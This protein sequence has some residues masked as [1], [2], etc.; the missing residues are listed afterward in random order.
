MAHAIIV[1]EIGGKQRT[2]CFNNH[3]VMFIGKAC[4]CDPIDIEA[5]IMKIATE[6]GLRAL[7]IVIYGGLCGWYE[8]EAIFDHDGVTLKDVTGWIGDANVDEFASVWNVFA[9]A[10]A[11][12]RATEKQIK[13]Y[14]NKLASGEIKKKTKKPKTSVH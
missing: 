5:E 9:E 11:L 1:I 3:A 10:L 8:R 4:K 7:A 14:E 6:N 12:P 2:V 13:E